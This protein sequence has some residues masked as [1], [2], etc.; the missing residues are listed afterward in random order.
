[1]GEG[2]IEGGGGVFGEVGNGGWE[3]REWEG[4]MM[5]EMMEDLLLIGLMFGIGGL[6][7]LRVRWVVMV[8]NGGRV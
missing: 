4:E 5:G 8:G 7:W 3:G 1:M 6:M 2:D